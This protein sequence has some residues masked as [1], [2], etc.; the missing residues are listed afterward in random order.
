MMSENTRCGFV[1]IVGR[2]N[3]GKSSL[4]NMILGKKVS[5]TSFRPQTTRQ[6]ILGIHTENQSQTIYVDTPGFQLGAKSVFNQ[7]MN[8]AAKHALQDVDV[9]VFVV[10]ALKWTDEDN[11]VLELIQGLK[12]PILVAINKIDLLEDK[13]RLLSYIEK[14]SGYLPR[15]EFV[16]LSALDQIQTHVISEK[17]SAHL[18]PSPFYFP[19]DQSTNRPEVF[20]MAELIREKLMIL[21]DAELPYSVCVEIEKVEQTEKIV[22]IHALIWT[23]REGQKRIIIGENGSK[24]KQ[25]GIRARKDLEYFLKKKVNL[26]LWVKVKAWSSSVI[27]LKNLGLLE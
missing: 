1:A 14:I 18:P 4:L 17:V 3:V 6:Q 25:I 11:A 2:P 16:P 22:H 13:N 12:C 9:V 19:A 10:E 27:E 23:E 5:I 8:K 20:M 15:A 24:L 7:Q 26:K 21:L